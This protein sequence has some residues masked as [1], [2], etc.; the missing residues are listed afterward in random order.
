MKKITPA[1]KTEQNMPFKIS[2]D[3]F[4]HFRYVWVHPYIISIAQN[5]NFVKHNILLYSDEKSKRTVYECV[6]KQISN[7]SVHFCEK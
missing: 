3:I 6:H 1:E 2:A 4:F 7:P 5:K